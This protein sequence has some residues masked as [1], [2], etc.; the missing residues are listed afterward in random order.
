MKKL[1]NRA[2]K[3]DRLVKK[4]GNAT[5]KMIEMFRT[6]M[7]TAPLSVL[8]NG[9]DFVPV[10]N[11]AL[12]VN[13]SAETRH[14]ESKLRH[15]HIKRPL[16]TFMLYR[17]AYIDRAKAWCLENKQDTLSII[18]GQSWSLEPENLRNMYREYTRLEESNHR[19][20]YP[21]YKFSLR[22]TSLSCPQRQRN[23]SID[24]NLEHF[25]ATQ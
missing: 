21:T 19:L 13:R 7:L 17:S 23:I 2:K 22:Q 14:L 24:Q 1:K 18:L 8:M 5:N 12:W 3:N 15:G 20:A 16:N 9:R 6:R 25:K 4:E 10:R 11:I